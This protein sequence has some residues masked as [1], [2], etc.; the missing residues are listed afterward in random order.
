MRRRLLALSV[1]LALASA[2]A[3]EF[4]EDPATSGVITLHDGNGKVFSYNFGEKLPA[5][6]D[7][8]FI[9]SSFLH[10]IWDLN[11]NI[12]TDNFPKDHF[13]HHG[14]FWGWPIVKTRGVTTDNWMHGNPSLRPHFVRWVTKTANEKLAVLTMENRWLL[15]E[16]EE[17]VRELVT[18]QT[19]PIQN[20][21]RAIDVQIK[22]EAVGGPLTLQGSQ[23]GKKGYGG[24]SYRAAS[25]LKGA[26]IS[27]DT[28]IKSKD[29]MMERAR[30]SDL[31]TTQTG[32]AIFIAPDHPDYPPFSFARNS[33]TGFLNPSWPGLDS[34]ELLPGKPVTL[35]YRLYIHQGN[36][37]IENIQAAYD[38]Y[39]RQFESPPA[40]SLL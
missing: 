16:K 5:G 30:W 15:D 29:I 17:V 23:E 11:G 13:H 26:R 21:S 25:A 10:P 27:T 4:V 32:I 2:Q 22:L 34:T 12:L 6:V 38:D 24:L 3:M 37:P 33:Y 7:S 39:V 9:R 1:I 8:K 18:I 36:L 35:R 28:G 19:H 40:Q 14:V 20:N 31:T